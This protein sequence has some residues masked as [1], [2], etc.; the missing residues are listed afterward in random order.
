LTKYSSRFKVPSDQ[1]LVV[2]RLRRQPSRRI[3]NKLRGTLWLETVKLEKVA[4]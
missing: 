3:D 2:V 4:G 1:S